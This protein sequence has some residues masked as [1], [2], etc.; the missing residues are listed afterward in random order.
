MVGVYSDKAWL[1]Q[2]VQAVAYVIASN[3]F[4]AMVLIA[5][6]VWALAFIW[7]TVLWLDGRPYF[8]LF[9]DAMISMRYAA[10]LVDGQGLVWNLGK[11]V[12][13]YTDPLW[14]LYMAIIIALFGKNLAPLAIQFTGMA[15]MMSTVAVAVCAARDAWPMEENS[16]LGPRT[17]T[18]GV[19]LA[20]M[21]TFYPLHYWSLMGMEVSLLSAVT[22]ASAFVLVRVE[23]GR[24]AATLGFALLLAAIL[25]AY[26]SRPD[27]FLV[28]MPLLAVC[29]LRAL[30]Q[31]PR[32]AITIG[33]AGGGIIVALVAWHLE[34]RLHYYG[35][36]EPN[37]YTLKVAGYSLRLRLA[38][39][40][41]FLLRFFVFY[42]LTILTAV[43]AFILFARKSL[44]VKALL[45]SCA[46][47]I[48]YQLY[49]GG[50]PWLY[51][52]QLVP[53]IVLLYIGMAI[54]IG[55]GLKRVPVDKRPIPFALTVGGV[56]TLCVVSNAPFVPQ[57]IALT[58]PY[59][60]A[61]NEEDVATAIALR[62][63]LQPSATVLAFWAGAIPYY[64]GGNA[65]DPLGKSDSYIAGLPVDLTVTW[66]GMKG[67]PGHAKH[68]LEYSIVGAKPD[69]VQFLTWGSDRSAARWDRQYISVQYK[70]LTLCLR[71]RST[72][73]HWNLVKVIGKCPES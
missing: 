25:V 60:V 73:V 26:F 72:L 38:N 22:A 31:A 48:A 24:L 32:R 21:A 40:L 14:T 51:W 55:A 12:E 11:G 17:L 66:G 3:R 58:K 7:R 52:R 63:V 23:T 39:G 15:L 9:D 20:L 36:L 70:H 35:A 54:S 5:L 47:S 68:D 10:N 59:T 53:G 13:G 71:D 61:A 33:L 16:K 44:M 42:G 46:L 2:K 56:L 8:S 65:I 19:A 41:G 18:F 69:Y 64:W 27:G 30:Q 34:W 49:V 45:I 37:T 29:A 43:L 57:I 62:E 67:V 6:G 4:F 50:D 1:P 28:L